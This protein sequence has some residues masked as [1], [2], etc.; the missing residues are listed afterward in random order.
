MY[1]DDG[2]AQKKCPCFATMKN[3]GSLSLLLD[4]NVTVILP[5]GSEGP[6]FVVTNYTSIPFTQ[7]WTLNNKIPSGQTAA[8]NKYND[9][10]LDSWF[11]MV[12]GG[13]EF[14][15]SI[16][17]FWAAGW[18]QR[19]QMI[20]QGTS[21][22]NSNVRNSQ[23]TMIDSSEIKFHLT[24][25]E[26]NKKD[27]GTDVD[28][29]PFQANLDLDTDESHGVK[30]PVP[31]NN[32]DDGVGGDN[33]ADLPQENEQVGNDDAGDDAG[34]EVNDDADAEGENNASDREGDV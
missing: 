7:L 5:N 31:G 3:R 33:N 1:G 28:L 19:G 17:E 10:F 8:V 27:D 16:S 4:V 26:P 24:C 11:D 25:L 34:D 22:S 9:A 18:L 32:D 23:Q 15:N 2:V 12:I 30:A 29:S 21:N 6:S 20:D 13:C 14:V